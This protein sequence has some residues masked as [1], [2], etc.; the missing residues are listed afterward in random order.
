MYA[1]T[2]YALGVEINRAYA[3]NMVKSALEH[4]RRH[5]YH[6]LELL[7]V[8]HP[9]KLRF[10]RS[11]RSQMLPRRVWSR[12][13]GRMRAGHGRVPWRVGWLWSNGLSTI[14][15][16]SN[17]LIVFGTRGAFDR[18]TEDRRRRTIRGFEL[19]KADRRQAKAT[20]SIPGEL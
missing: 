4:V 10:V 17:A 14:D 8:P 12:H 7:F 18:S 13:A 9:C 11:F 15:T 1:V 2:V 3:E 16:A 19:L 6:A 20:C 5:G